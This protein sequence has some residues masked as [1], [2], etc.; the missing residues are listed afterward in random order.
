[1]RRGTADGYR[2]GEILRPQ[3]S[4][5]QVARPDQGHIGD[6]IPCNRYAVGPPVD[7]SGT[8]DNTGGMGWESAASDRP[9]SD[10][11]LTE[12]RPTVWEERW[13]G[14]RGNCGTRDP[15]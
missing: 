3:F 12:I 1:M 10:R 2:I 7:H 6:A 14:I 5:L 15:L 8:R 9:D 11:S 4:P 13:A